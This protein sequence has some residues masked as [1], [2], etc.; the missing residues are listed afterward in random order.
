MSVTAVTARQNYT[1][2]ERCLDVAD[3]GEEGERLKTEMKHVRMN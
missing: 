3:T 2:Q 1:S